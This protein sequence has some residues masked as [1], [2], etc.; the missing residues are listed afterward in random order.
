MDTCKSVLIPWKAIS[1][2][3]LSERTYKIGPTTLVTFEGTIK[4][5]EVCRQ[6]KQMHS[7]SA[8]FTKE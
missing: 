3:K 8:Q 6:L 5:A 7:P 2:T 1:T 4:S